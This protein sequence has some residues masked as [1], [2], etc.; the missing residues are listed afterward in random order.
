MLDFVPTVTPVS[1]SSTEV[2]SEHTSKSYPHMSPE[3]EKHVEK[4]S[5]SRDFFGNVSMAGRFQT[6]ATIR[7]LFI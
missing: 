7:P 1:H 6:E 2:E 3:I 5:R 4:I